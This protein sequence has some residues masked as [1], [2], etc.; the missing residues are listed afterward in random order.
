MSDNDCILK[1]QEIKTKRS[2]RKTYI[3]CDTCIYKDTKECENLKA[4]RG[5][6]QTK[7]D[8]LK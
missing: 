7:E 5:A 3:S 6:R 2:K 8:L 1:H 4:W